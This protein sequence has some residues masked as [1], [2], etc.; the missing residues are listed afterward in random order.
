MLGK[1]VIGI[2]FPDEKCVIKDDII[3]WFLMGLLSQI[4]TLRWCVLVIR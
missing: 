1:W 3:Y 2:L 4:Y